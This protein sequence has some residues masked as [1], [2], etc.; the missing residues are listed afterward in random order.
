MYSIAKL[1]LCTVA[2]VVSLVTTASFPFFAQLDEK[3]EVKKTLLAVLAH[4]EENSKMMRNFNVF[5]NQAYWVHYEVY[6]S[7]MNYL[8]SGELID[9]LLYMS[10]K[11]PLDDFPGLANVV[12]AIIEKKMLYI[13]VYSK[14]TLK[15][16]EV[17][18]KS[19][20]YEESHKWALNVLRH[21]KTEDG[22][23]RLCELMFGIKYML[24]AP[25]LQYCLH[26]VENVFCVPM[27]HCS[28]LEF[29]QTVIKLDLWAKRQGVNAWRCFV[30]KIRPLQGFVD[31]DFLYSS[32]D[33]TTLTVKHNDSRC[34]AH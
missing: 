3:S 22:L 20:N 1:S 31:Y 33:E 10:D 9:F 8:P 34:F 27:M 5:L 12:E 21:A 18:H 6:K 23:R 13:I 16:T 2:V 4:Y 32:H 28:H 29:L 26:T 17:D 14:F 25:I 11:G 15:L 24:T 7:I 30:A 19:C